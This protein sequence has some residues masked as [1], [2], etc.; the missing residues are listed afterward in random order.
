MIIILNK[1]KIIIMPDKHE[2]SHQ[3]LIQ[4][5]NSL[6]MKTIWPIKTYYHKSNAKAIKVTKI[7]LFKIR[8]KQENLVQLKKFSLINEIFN[9]LI[10]INNKL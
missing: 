6:I 7:T 2:L 3:I 5:L 4:R 8:E 10:Y 1:S 9:I